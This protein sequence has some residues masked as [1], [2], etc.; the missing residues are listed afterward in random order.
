LHRNA[1]GLLWGLAKVAHC[2]SAALDSNIKDLT[3]L[4]FQLSSKRWPRSWD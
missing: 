4:E 3:L 1:A 2:E